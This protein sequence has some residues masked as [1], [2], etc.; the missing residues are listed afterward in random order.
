MARAAAEK[1]EK[2]IK[3]HTARLGQLFNTTLKDELKKTLGLKN[4][5]EVPKLSKVVLN[6]G[7]KEAVADS[8]ILEK[9]E[10]TMTQIAGQAPVRTKARKSIASF[11]IREGMPLGICVTLRGRRMY[12]FIDK[13]INLALPRV[14]DFQGVPRKFDGRG[15]Y[16]LGIKE[17]TIF[18]EVDSMGIEKIHGLNI[19]IHTTALTDEHGYELLKVLGMPFKKK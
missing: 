8:R 2:S 13:L 15:S 4:I 5:M 12:D 6:V 7:V 19:T 14:R 11:K 1:K 16:N 3:G 10:Q 9:V 17:W 18:P